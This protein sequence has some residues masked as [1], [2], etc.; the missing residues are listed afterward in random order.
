MEL[1]LKKVAKEYLDINGVDFLIWKG[2][3]SEYVPDAMG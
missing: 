1:D 2:D 3:P